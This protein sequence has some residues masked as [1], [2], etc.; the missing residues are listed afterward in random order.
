[1]SSPSR[2]DR[3]IATRAAAAACPAW[4]RWPRPRPARPRTRPRSSSGQLESALVQADV[5]HWAYAGTWPKSPSCAPEPEQ[6]PGSA[7]SVPAVSPPGNPAPARPAQEF[8]RHRRAL[9]RICPCRGARRKRHPP[10][11]RSEGQARGDGRGGLGHAGRCAPR[12]RSRGAFGMRP[13]AQLP[14][15]VAS[16]G[17]A[18]PRRHRRALPG[19]RISGAGGGRSRLAGQDAA[20]AGAG[21]NGA[22]APRQIPVLR[23]GRDPGRDISRHRQGNAVGRG[24]GV[25]GGARRDAG[26]SGLRHHLGAVAAGLAPHP[27][28]RPPGGQAHPPGRRAGRLR[29]AAP[30]RRRAL[31]PRARAGFEPKRCPTGR[32][33]CRRWRL[34]KERKV[35]PRSWR[36]APCRSAPCRRTPDRCRPAAR[37][38]RPRSRAIRR[39]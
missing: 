6:A 36:A 30:P 2:R 5:A 9:S 15:P 37:A 14:A 26:G 23:G 24:D 31:L 22:R 21:G 33:R 11:G 39:K 3:A 34:A 4:S 38:P 20:G 18:A 10:P 27:R 35:R 7:A 16:G 13:Q 17:G 8:A 1:M 12:A 28:Q 29:P 19:G 32:R 25:V